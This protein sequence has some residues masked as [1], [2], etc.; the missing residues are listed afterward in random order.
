[1]MWHAAADRR[2]PP[3]ASVLDGVP[4]D[5]ARVIDRLTAKDQSQ[6]YRT[7]EQALADL[8]TAP[9]ITG[10]AAADDEDAAAQ[11]RQKFQRRM[12]ASLALFAS[13]LVSTIIAVMPTG[14]KA[15]PTPAEPM[16]VRG[17]VRMLIPDRQTL[18]VEQA[19]SAGPKEIVVRSDDRIYLNDKASLLRELREADQVTVQTLRDEQGRPLLEIQASRPREDR[20]TI[21]GVNP[22]TAS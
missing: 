19:S 12:V 15:T 17:V 5:L 4:D 3:V 14:K 18:I 1:M 11:R 9:P 22:M 10:D 6:R 20:G 13:V 16:A 21:A 8:G 7:A 2:L